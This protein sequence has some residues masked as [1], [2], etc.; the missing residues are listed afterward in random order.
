MRAHCYIVDLDINFVSET[1][2]CDIP[3]LEESLDDT[4]W[5]SKGG[6][7]ESC[8]YRNNATV[9]RYTKMPLIDVDWC[10]TVLEDNTLNRQAEEMWTSTLIITTHMALLVYRVPLSDK[11][12][13]KNVATVWQSTCS[14]NPWPQN[15]KEAQFEHA[16]K[17]HRY[18]SA[19]QIGTSKIQKIN[20]LHYV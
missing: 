14:C 20:V 18:N 19:F 15:A 1:G 9:S 3:R 11:E 12:V 17:H 10:R 6:L 13:I 2:L 8:Q 7:F 4:D 16:Q 5:P